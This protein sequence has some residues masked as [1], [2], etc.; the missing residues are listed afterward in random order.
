MHPIT[1]SEIAILLKIVQN[2]D[3]YNLEVEKSPIAPKAR[4]VTFASCP[5]LTYKDFV[6]GVVV[7]TLEGDHSIGDVIKAQPT[8]TLLATLNLC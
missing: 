7:L 8:P 5:L 2:S 3:N 6:E 4:F 1:I